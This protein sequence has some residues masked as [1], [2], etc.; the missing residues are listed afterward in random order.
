MFR[1]GWLVEDGEVSLVVLVM[2]GLGKL[3]G[4]VVYVWLERCGL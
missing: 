4:M 1:L 3:V 2:V